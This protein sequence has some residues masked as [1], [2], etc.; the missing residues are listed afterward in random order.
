MSELGPVSWGTRSYLTQVDSY[1]GSRKQFWN[2]VFYAQSHL[3]IDLEL[4][5]ACEIILRYYLTYGI[6][7]SLPVRK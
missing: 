2:I 4:G 1:P 6:A 5:C 3:C 7:G